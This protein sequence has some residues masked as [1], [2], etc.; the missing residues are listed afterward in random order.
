MSK[1][2]S[3]NKKSKRST[4]H[5][6]EEHP[7]ISIPKLLALPKIQHQLKGASKV[8]EVSRNQRR[9]LESYETEM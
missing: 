1:S 8:L 9:L 6:E 3:T 2:Q 4:P 5:N 7:S